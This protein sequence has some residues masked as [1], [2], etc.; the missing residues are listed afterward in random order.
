MSGKINNS[1]A[2]PTNICDHQQQQPSKPISGPSISVAKSPSKSVLNV[3][4]F[5]HD[6]SAIEISCYPQYQQGPVLI[7][8]VSLAA[9]HVNY[10]KKKKH[11]YK[12]VQA[13][14]TINMNSRYAC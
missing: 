1:F 8:N 4:C 14:V 6:F 3:N 9:V 13:S 2:T 7:C 5:I 12:Y 11:V 10:R